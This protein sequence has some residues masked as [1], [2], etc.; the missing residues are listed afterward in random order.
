MKKLYNLTAEHSAQ[1]KPW[2]EKWIANAMSTVAMDDGEREITRRAIVGLYLAAKLPP[3]KQIV[4]MSSPRA[5]VLAGAYAAAGICSLRKGPQTS[6]DL[7]LAPQLA[8]N[9]EVSQATQIEVWQ[10][11]EMVVDQATDA[12]V[13]TPTRLMVQLAD[14]FEKRDN[15]KI[16]YN[17]G[18]QS[19]AWCSYFSFFRHV[20][21]L[22]LPE[23]E[24]W[25]HYESAALHSGPRYMHPEFCIVS[26][27]PGKPRRIQALAEEVK[28]KPEPREVTIPVVDYAVQGD[29][30]IHMNVLSDN[31][32]SALTQP[33]LEQVL[34]DG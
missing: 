12:S 17:G 6:P 1:L 11:T 31:F 30:Y 28:G 7:N 15:W 27:R 25:Q 32:N 19:S 8:S 9:Q 13:S 4:F 14:Q 23:Y 3:P 22:Q 29:V 2:A 33:Q 20:V 24:H 10:A 16:N 34:L 5:A 18:N 26:D 21:G